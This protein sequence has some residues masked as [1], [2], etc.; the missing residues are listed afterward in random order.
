MVF[1]TLFHSEY[2]KVPGKIRDVDYQ[3]QE[4]EMDGWARWDMPSNDYYDLEEFP[5]GYTGYD[6]SSIWNY[7]HN[8]ICFA[9]YNDGDEHWKADFNKAVSGAHS[10]VSVQVVQGIQDKIDIDEEF[11]DDE[12][13]RDPRQ[14]FGRR[15][16][17]SGETPLALENLYFTYM[18]CLSAAAKV[19][20]K[21]LSDCQSGMI[22]GPS[23][24]V[25]ESFLS[26]P[27]LADSALQLV[28][29]TLQDK[30]VRSSD[31]LWEARQRSRELLRIMNCVQCNKCR[32]HG[33][34]AV[35]GLSTALQ[36]HVGHVQ[37]QD[38][39]QIKRV[40]LAALM[41]TIHRL[42]KAINYCQGML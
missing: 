24:A 38:P 22:D 12:V 30:A 6:G 13:W 39:N 33:K 26:H 17:T 42:S 7:I 35:M 37:G 4:F 34:L 23:A 19:K 27:I 36:I 14:E 2:E 16:S 28:S 10:L 18:L 3:E 5:E 11:T 20:T 29:Q 32:L 25:I 9:G 31:T 8:K 40:E 15:L 21:L 41:T 1:C